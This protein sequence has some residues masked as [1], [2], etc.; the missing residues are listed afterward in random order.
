[1]FEQ[2]S[3]ILE[4]AKHSEKTIKDSFNS[5]R[6]KNTIDIQKLLNSEL[7]R[8]SMDNEED[9]ELNTLFNSIWKKLITYNISSNKSVFETYKIINKCNTHGGCP[10]YVCRV[11]FTLI[12]IKSEHFN[13]EAGD[14]V[15]LEWLKIDGSSRDNDT[16]DSVFNTSHIRDDEYGYSIPTFDGPGSITGAPNF[17]EYIGGPDSSSHPKIS[18]NIKKWWEEWVSANRPI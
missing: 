3:N 11:W 17:S 18:P 8:T 5:K 9:I 6:E 2:L 13:C 12:P 15:R 14:P 4:E 10:Y 7:E 16:T 1:M